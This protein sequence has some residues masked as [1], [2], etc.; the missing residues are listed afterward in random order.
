MR[1]LLYHL[2]VP[3]SDNNKNP[4]VTN[5]SYSHNIAH[6]QPCVYSLLIL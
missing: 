2:G 3:H 6:L 1:I 4:Y 5:R